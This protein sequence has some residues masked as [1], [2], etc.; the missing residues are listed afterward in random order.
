MEA[1]GSE[2][3]SDSPRPVRQD[4]LE[5]RAHEADI[6]HELAPPGLFRFL[7]EAAWKHAEELGFGY[8]HLGR[9]ALLWVLA[10]ITMEVTRFPRWGEAVRVETWP[11]GTHRL[12]AL[13]DFRV[14]D[15]EERELTRA[16]SGWLVL[17]ATTRKPRKPETVM[18]SENTPLSPG[19]FDDPP[20]KISLP[21]ELTRPSGGKRAEPDSA[22]GSAF[23]A[24]CAK[25]AALPH[26]P[27][28]EERLVRYSDLDTQRHVN[29]A[30]YL[31]WIWDTLPW[32][33]HVKQRAVV[34]DANFLRETNYGDRVT[35]AT[36]PNVGNPVGNHSNTRKE[37]PRRETYHIVS[38][39]ETGA[40]TARVL[41]APRG[42]TG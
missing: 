42:A 25:P 27:S 23:A 13:R 2:S 30:K 37:I 31:E 35:V 17:D 41:W 21:E 20:R 14:Y 19:I 5:V 9:Q 15:E 1:Y 8:S 4:V 7:Q 6:N 16:T 39:N 26:E 10:R 32:D 3:V 28:N 12:L 22:G 11:V 34:L 18:N 40:C 38:A 24:E 29:N 36:H 33:Q